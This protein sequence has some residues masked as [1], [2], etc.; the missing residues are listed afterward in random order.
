MASIRTKYL[1]LPQSACM[2]E[3]CVSRRNTNIS[4]PNSISSSKSETSLSSTRVLK[5]FYDSIQQIKL[6]IL[7]HD[8]SAFRKSV[9]FIQ[10]I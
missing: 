7:I 2:K 3:M 1:R 6:E 8:V 5:W 9:C 4:E 10:K